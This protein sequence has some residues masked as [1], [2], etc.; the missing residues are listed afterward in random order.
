VTFSINGLVYTIVDADNNI[1]FT[2]ATQVALT[3]CLYLVCIDKDN[4]I[5]VIKGDEVV[6]ATLTAENTVLNWPVPTVKTCPIGAVKVV[7]T[8]V[9]TRGTTELGTGNAA[10]YYDLL[11]VPTAPLTS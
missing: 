5:T 7:A 1:E 11:A 4:T 2:A 9:F 3:T 8:A 6:T 10:T